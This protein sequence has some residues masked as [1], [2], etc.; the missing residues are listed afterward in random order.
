MIHENRRIRSLVP[1]GTVAMA[2][3]V[4]DMISA[5]MDIID[6]TAGEPDYN[7][8]DHILDE[9]FRAARSGQTR[10][11]AVAGTLTL[12]EAI[13]DQYKHKHELAYNPRNII[14]GTG[15][16]QMIF[17]AMMASLEPGDEV[18]IPA[19]YWPS[20][21][22]IVT[23]A[24]GKPVIVNCSVKSDYK[25]T[26]TK[27]YSVISSSTRWLIINSPNNPTGAVYSRN[28]L[29]DIARVL[30]MYPD[31]SV[32]CD[33]IYE[34]ILFDGRIFSN[35]AMVAPEMMDRILLVGGV[36]KSDAMTGWRIGYAAGP[37][38]FISQMTILQGQSTTCASSISQAAA[39]AAL[40]GRR[41]HIKSWNVAY[42]VRRDLV[43]E[44]LHDTPGLTLYKPEG[45]FYHYIDCT[46]LLGSR[47]PDGGILDNDIQLSTYLLE[48]ANVGVVPGSVFGGEGCI[49]LCFACSEEKLD[50]ACRRIKHSLDKLI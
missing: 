11:T 27:L 48:M 19:P 13:A 44:K 20:F 34:S 31:I 24:G 10:Y 18:I 21:P 50:H 26:P 46:G 41:D 15:G 36:S 32:L 28:E 3:K 39:L 40:S 1:S 38:D 7:T 43:F 16:K 37:E 49:R 25:I 6:L 35:L 30:Q 23:F 17:N 29:L 5:G 45:A 4:R 22:D 42:Q 2:S 14:V 33:D 12:R 47:T 8:P 9:A